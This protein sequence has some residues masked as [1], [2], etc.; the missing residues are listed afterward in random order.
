MNAEKPPNL[1]ADGPE[2]DEELSEI[3]LEEDSGYMEPSLTMLSLLHCILSLSMLVSYYRLKVPAYQLWLTLIC[4]LTKLL[5][6][7][8]R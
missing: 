3:T 2:T 7:K 8:F 1:E 4:K 6:E 5:E